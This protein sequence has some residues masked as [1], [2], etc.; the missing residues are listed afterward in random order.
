MAAHPI[1]RAAEWLATLNITLA[2]LVQCHR[3]LCALWQT[4]F[5][6]LFSAGTALLIKIWHTVVYFEFHTAFELRYM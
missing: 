4:R 2:R 1:P 5:C 3:A 6:L